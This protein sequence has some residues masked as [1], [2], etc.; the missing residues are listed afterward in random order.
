MHDGGA[1]AIASACSDG[2]AATVEEGTGCGVAGREYV[3]L[4]VSA[5][6]GPSSCALGFPEVRGEMAGLEVR[7][8]C[9]SVQ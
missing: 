8:V 5:L 3:S 2:L 7:R 4:F 6:P 1:V 9:A